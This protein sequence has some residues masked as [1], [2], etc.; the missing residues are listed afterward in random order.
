MIYY[1]NDTQ[2]ELGGTSQPTIGEL[3]FVF[4][5]RRIQIKL[6]P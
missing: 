2:G 4:N 6:K 5:I 3:Q 1:D